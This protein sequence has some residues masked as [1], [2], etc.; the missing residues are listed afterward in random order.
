MGVV[1]CG[2]LLSVL[3]PEPL[4]RE[5]QQAQV[6]SAAAVRRG[7]GENFSKPV[8]PSALFGDLRLTVSSDSKAHVAFSMRAG[9]DGRLRKV[10]RNAEIKRLSESSWVVFLGGVGATPNV[11][12]PPRGPVARLE[13]KPVRRGVVLVIELTQVASRRV[14]RHRP[15]FEVVKN[16]RVLMVGRM[17]DAVSDPEEYVFSAV[18]PLSRILGSKATLKKSIPT[19]AVE[20]TKTALTSAA[21][22]L[23]GNGPIMSPVL[24]MATGLLGMLGVLLWLRKKQRPISTAG[25]IDIVSIK[26]LGSKTKLAVVEACGDRILVAASDKGVQMLSRVGERDEGFSRHLEQRLQ[27]RDV[28]RQGDDDLAGL[29]A[30]RRD[31]LTQ[32]RDDERPRKGLRAA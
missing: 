31:D 11:V 29:L 1:L 13:V 30:L 19:S 27:T 20:P 7:N 4:A 16:E 17:R 28:P 2:A 15:R 5:H 14:H 10:M 3:N 26:A 22:A 9:T 23:A 8:N 6:S 21:P 18:S 24:L 12:T 25:A 32:T